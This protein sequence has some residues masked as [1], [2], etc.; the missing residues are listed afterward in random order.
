MAKGFTPR[1]KGHLD[2]GTTGGPGIAKDVGGDRLRLGIINVSHL[3]PP[4]PPGS[5]LPSGTPASPFD[6]FS[7][8]EHTHTELMRMMGGDG[9]DGEGSMGPPGPA[10]ADGIPGG[11]PGPAGAD[12]SDGATGAPGQQGHPGPSGEDGDDGPYGPPGNVGATGTAGAP[13]ADGLMGIPGIRG[14]DGE[15][16]PIIGFPSSAQFLYAN[17]IV[18]IDGGGVI[19]TTG[20]KVDLVVDFACVVTDWTLL[21]DVADTFRIDVWKDLYANYPPVV[22]D[23][24]P[25]ADGNK[26]QTGAVVKASGGVV[27]WT[28]AVLA[29][30]DTLRFNVDVS[31]TATRATLALK[32]RRI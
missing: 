3:S 1:S 31:A 11:P 7:G 15:D 24:M 23:S 19:I 32:V 27:G 14:D 13:G 16:G 12:G 29:A 25:G 21:L 17:L 6:A 10:G 28:T 22:G 4:R 26:P 18:V 8:T 2:S 30:G 20:I 9:G 5:A